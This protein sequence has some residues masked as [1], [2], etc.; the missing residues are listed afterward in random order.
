MG[1]PIDYFTVERI[2]LSLQTTSQLHLHSSTWEGWS[3][4]DRLVI[5]VL[6]LRGAIQDDYSDGDMFS[7]DNVLTVKCSTV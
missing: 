3:L 7:A 6:A 1:D 4:E 5:M 2:M